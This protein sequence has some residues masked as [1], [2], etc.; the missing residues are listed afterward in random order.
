[1]TKL[2]HKAID[3]TGQLFGRLTVLK[4]TQRRKSGCIVWLCGCSCG[5]K[6][7]VNTGHLQKGNTKSCGCLARN[8]LIKRS[9]VHKMAKTRIYK[10]WIGMIQRC[11]NPNNQAYKR[12]GSRG[13]RVCE[14]WHSFENFYA[15]V[16]N[17]PEG[18]TLDRWPDNDGDYELSNFRWATPGQQALN[19]RPRFCGP[20]KQRWF[21]GHGPNDEMI[22]ENN[23]SHIARMLG[24][25]RKSIS[26]CLKGKRPHHEGWTF[27]WIP[28]QA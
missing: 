6:C 2:H 17:R 19:R 22:L 11:E 13:I 7:F 1:M 18:M 20:R 5:N 21:Y 25:S 3:L 23:Q 9:T 15:D 12:Y 24:L 10:A 26:K 4:P 14:R 8:L 16:G 27:G 28:E